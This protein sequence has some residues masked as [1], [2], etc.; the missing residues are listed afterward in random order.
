MPDEMQQNSEDSASHAFAEPQ[1]GAFALAESL[2]IECSGETLRVKIRH[3]PALTGWEVR[4]RYREFLESKDPSFRLGFTVSVLSY[5]SI[6]GTEDIAP[7]NTAD[8]INSRLR[9]W[10]NVEKVFNAVLGYNGIRTD[11]A[12]VERLRWQVA[13]EDMAA[14]FLAAVQSLIGPALTIA[15]NKK[16]EE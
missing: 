3:F 2:E 14:T 8:I 13:G 15:A 16:A 7:L 9:K 11:P 5:A 1:A 10:Q 4:R 12:E 6:E